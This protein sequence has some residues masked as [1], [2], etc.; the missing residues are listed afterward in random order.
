MLID[1]NTNDHVTTEDEEES[2][3]CY[4]DDGLTTDQPKEDT[5]MKTTNINKQA[6]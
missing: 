3:A 4:E 6:R 2:L 5:T 1:K